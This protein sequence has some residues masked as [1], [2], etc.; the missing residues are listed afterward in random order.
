MLP[1]QFV[2]SGLL[3]DISK[4]NVFVSTVSFQ[5]IKTWCYVNREYNVDCNS[6]PQYFSLNEALYKSPEK[7]YQAINPAIKIVQVTLL[8]YPCSNNTVI[9]ERVA[10]R[11]RLLWS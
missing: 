4:F 11:S 6:A 8:R 1:K 7:I 3:S 9:V 10:P 2:T 5:I